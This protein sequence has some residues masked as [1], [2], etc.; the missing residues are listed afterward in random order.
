[1]AMKENWNKLDKPAHIRL[2]ILALIILNWRQKIRAA[3]AKPWSISGKLESPSPGSWLNSGQYG[4]LKFKN[5]DLA[6][7]YTLAWIRVRFSC[8]EGDQIL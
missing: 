4:F 3:R 2:V 8:Q 7:L 1:M 5:H 6:F